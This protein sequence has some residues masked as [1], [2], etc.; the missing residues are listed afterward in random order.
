MCLNVGLSSRLLE[1]M[2]G[3]W[4]KSSPVG[5]NSVAKS[6]IGGWPRPLMISISTLLSTNEEQISCSSF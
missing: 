2:I 1:D 5:M 6:F 3:K 4:V